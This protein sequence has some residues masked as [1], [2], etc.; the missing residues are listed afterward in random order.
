MS[1]KD[2]ENGL[3]SDNKNETSSFLTFVLFILNIIIFANTNSNDFDTISDKCFYYFHRNMMICGIIMYGLSIL[4]TCFTRVS[5]MTITNNYF[6][7]TMLFCQGIL[8]IGILVTVAVQY[9][10]LGILWQKYPEHTI[11]FYPEFWNE[12]LSN[13][14]N[15]TV[16][17][18]PYVMSDVVVRIDSFC[19]M[20]LP[21]ILGFALFCTG[22]V[23]CYTTA[24]PPRKRVHPTLEGNM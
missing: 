11:M 1:T 23:M 17:H 19:F 13:F 4:L 14:N 18:W 8:V 16:E 12:G 9:W 2:I 7:Y 6:K 20:S 21:I 24:C 3:S 15:T 22:S 10:Q 5:A